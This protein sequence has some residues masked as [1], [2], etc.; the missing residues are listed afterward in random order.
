MIFMRKMLLNRKIIPNRQICSEIDMAT[1]FIKYTYLFYFFCSFQ[2][3]LIDV[4]I[5]KSPYQ[6]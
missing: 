6:D 3:N 4:V 2:R 5:V 1:T